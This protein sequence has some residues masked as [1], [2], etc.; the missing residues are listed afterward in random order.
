MRA[1]QGTD[2]LSPSGSCRA[3]T[4]GVFLALAVSG[5]FLLAWNHGWLL[6]YM[7]ATGSALAALLCCGLLVQTRARAR[8]AL[9]RAEAQ[10]DEVRR[11]LVDVERVGQI[12]HWISR[13]TTRTV[14]WSP[15]IFEIAGIPSVPA[16]SVSEAQ[17][18]IHPDDLPA[19]AAV[20]KEA[21]RTGQTRSCEHRWVRPDGDIRWVH[22]DVSPRYDAAGIWSELLGTVR[23]ITER[24]AA[25]AS[26]KDAQQQLVD[27]IEAISEGFV[28]WDKDDRFVLANGNFRR[29]WP[30]LDDVLVPGTPFET[31]SRVA[32]ERGVLDIGDEDI[33][34][35]VRRT[36]AWHQACGQPDERKLRDGRWLLIAER[37]TRDGGVVGIR[38]DI[39]ERKHTEQALRAAREQLE[40][41][42]EA[43]SEGF[44]LFDK[45][46]RYV[47]T[48]SKYREMYPTMVDMFA[49]GTRY[50]DM[51]R[52]GLQRNLWVV[53]GDREAWLRQITA[54]HR[55][56]HEPQERQLSD[57]AGCGSP[58]AVPGTAVSSASAPTSPS[59]NAPRRT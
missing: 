57:G 9:R 23:D 13:N 40:E 25:E 7:V 44:V 32:V 1:A 33:D 35:Y 14:I 8:A 4:A 2:R 54:W 45:D 30:L 38:A 52:V 39:T 41:A 56:T 28:L 12:G 11:Q 17:A 55:A 19:F 15:Q 34:D 22:V 51:L 21:V 3:L 29:L 16:M 5:A 24:K 50:E 42:I 47:M 26:L 48:N 31:V 18:P 43:I 58:N 27:A 6:P 53:D 59:A 10:A 49:P 46:D 37:R 36:A 20:I